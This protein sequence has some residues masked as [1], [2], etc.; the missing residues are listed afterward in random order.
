MEV[1]LNERLTGPKLNALLEKPEADKLPFNL[2]I[3]PNLIVDEKKVQQLR[4]DINSSVKLKK[5]DNDLYRFKQSKDLLTETPAKKITPLIHN[6]I[7]SMQ[8]EVRSK[9]EKLTG[10]QL[11]GKNFDIT[12]S[13]YDQG[14]YLLCHNDDIKD[15][16]KNHRRALAFV[17]YLTTRPWTKQDGGSLILFESDA[18][19]EPVRINNCLSPRPNT[20]VVFETTST[21]WHSV[22][23]VLCKD[24][25]R[26]SINGW[27]HTDIVVPSARDDALDD[28]PERHI[29]PSPFSFVRPIPLDERLEH[30]FKDYFNPDYLM[31]KTCMLIRRR[32]KRDSEINLINFL[33]PLKLKEIS[34]AL[35]EATSDEANF[36][37]VGPYN[38]RNYRRIRVEKLPQICG[39]LHDAFRS[40]LFFMFLSRI[41]GLDLQPPSMKGA[42]DDATSQANSSSQE[43]ASN[44]SDDSE[45]ESDEDLDL[46]DE[47]GESDDN[48]DDDEA[49]GD[50]T[51]Q[52]QTENKQTQS[53]FDQYKG[54]KSTTTATAA[55]AADEGKPT[56]SKQRSQE[57]DKNKPKKRRRT[58][59]PLVRH[60]FRHLDAGSYTL[61]HDHGFEMGEKSAL[62]VILHFNH[63][64]EVNFEDGGYISYIDGA[65]EED[66]HDMEYELL[67]VEPKSN[68]LSLAYRCDEGTCRFLKYLNKSH[69]SPYQDLYCVY[70]ERP[71]DL[72]PKSGAYI[73]SSSTSGSS[74]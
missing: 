64:F 5:K 62:D 71:D 28:A 39:D 32:F 57:G 7:D 1:N 66:P 31:E 33:N 37:H 36:E 13:R 19:G 11:S 72:P 27:F 49:G 35:K 70:Y 18:T 3:F 20:L 9:M 53:I 42:T 48:D 73:S 34:E 65:P 40:E 59:D 8:D 44:D 2:Y 46:E 23:E 6:F 47:S 51:Q 10:K 68:C 29:E 58:A 12:A 15:S 4:D 50:D 41:T 17:Y 38:K 61:I 21:S 22:E 16:L 63:D 45:G 25:F 69:K 74:G 26:L 43:S 30:F 67:T 60:E 24:D 55:V 14:N 54:E 56:T 52:E